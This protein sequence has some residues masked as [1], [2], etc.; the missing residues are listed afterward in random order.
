MKPLRFQAQMVVFHAQQW[1]ARVAG[2][3]PPAG[4]PDDADYA[5]VQ[6]GVAAARAY[7]QAIP[8]EAFAD[9]DEAAVTAKLGPQEMTMTGGEWLTGFAVA[10]IHFHMTMAYAI[11]RARGAELGKRDIFPEGF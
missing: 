8:P 6:A 10:N 5:A 9:R 4:L 3:E 7:L 1:P 11:L 2:R